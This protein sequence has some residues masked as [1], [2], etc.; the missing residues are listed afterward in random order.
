MHQIYRELEDLAFEVLHPLRYRVID[1]AIK[2][3]TRGRKKILSKIKTSLRQKL[4]QND[5]KVNVTGRRKHCYGIYKKMKRQNKTLKE[6]LDV[7]A[8]KI[9]LNNIFIR[10]ILN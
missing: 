7:Y 6:V 2:T 1:Q 4:K 5:L 8:F 3:N 10:V 9:T